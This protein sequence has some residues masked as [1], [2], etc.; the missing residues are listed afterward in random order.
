MELLGGRAIHPI[1][2]RVGGFY[3]A[4][5]RG[6]LAP[7]AGPLERGARGR[8]LETVRWVAGFD[9]PEFERDYEFVA[10]RGPASYPIERGP[11]RLERAAW[12]SPPRDFDEHFVEEQVPHSNALHAPAGGRRAAI[13]PGRWPGTRSTLERLSPLAA[14]GRGARPGSAR[15]AATR[16][17]ASWCAAVEMVYAFEEALRL[18]DAYEAPDRASVEVR[19]A[20]RRRLR[21]HRGA[22]G[23]LYHRYDLDADGLIADGAHRAADVAEPGGHRGGPARG[24][25]SARLDLDDDDAARCEQTIRNYDPCI[26]CATHFLELTVERSWSPER[27]R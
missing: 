8:A 5:A 27:H 21:R 20:R 23:L 12:T 9:F 6:E 7:L 22:A 26:S 13:S 3:Q 24:R 11:H 14:R 2:V 19:A 25:R 18:I 17:A 15:P 10:L 16:S 4:P 1:N